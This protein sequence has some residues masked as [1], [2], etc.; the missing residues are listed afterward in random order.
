M[1]NAAQTPVQVMWSPDWI[2]IL[3]SGASKQKGRRRFGK[4]LL[5]KQEVIEW[6]VK[7]GDEATAWDVEDSLPEVLDTEKDRELLAQHGIDVES[8]LGRR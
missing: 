2:E 1:G 6:L 5:Q 7:N 3:R 8:V 4:M